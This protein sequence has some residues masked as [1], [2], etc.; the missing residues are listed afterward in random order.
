LDHHSEIP[1]CLG[2]YFGAIDLLGKES[3][4]KFAS[5]NPKKIGAAEMNLNRL[6]LILHFSMNSLQ[7]IALRVCAIH[8][9]QDYQTNAQFP[10][11][12][13]ETRPHLGAP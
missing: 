4:T 6:K 9:H 13:A 3:G 12:T 10:Y 7:L 11:L 8:K 5:L 1:D 2:N